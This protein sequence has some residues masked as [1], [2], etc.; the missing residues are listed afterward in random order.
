MARPCVFQSVE[1]EVNTF[2][3]SLFSISLFTETRVFRIHEAREEGIAVLTKYGNLPGLFPLEGGP[4]KFPLA[5]KTW[6][7]LTLRWVQQASYRA[8]FSKEWIVKTCKSTFMIDS[9]EFKGA[10]S[11]YGYVDAKRETWP[12][13]D[14]IKDCGVCPCATCRL[15]GEANDII[16]LD[17]GNYTPTYMYNQFFAKQVSALLLNSQL[18]LNACSSLFRQPANMATLVMCLPL[19]ETCSF[20]IPRTTLWSVWEN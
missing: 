11:R 6:R 13:E 15:T 5:A 18:T 7:T 9:P 3:V 10:Q 14:E 20:L 17:G 2:P 1:S 19:S 12:T 8:L 16:E 4:F